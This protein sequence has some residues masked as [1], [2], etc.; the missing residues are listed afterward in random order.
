MCKRRSDVA[1]KPRSGPSAQSAK[2]ADSLRT[3][4]SVFDVESLRPLQQEAIDADMQQRDSLCVLPTGHGKSL[5]YQGPAIFGSGVTVV[6]S[7]LIAL[8]DDQVASISSGRPNRPGWAAALHSGI[9]PAAQAKIEQAVT[10]G[11]T[12]LLYCSPERALTPS[13]ITLLK[14]AGLRSIVID[15]AHCISQWGH[16]FRPDYAQ[17]GTLRTVFADV[18]MHAFTATA[19]P[20]V[21]ADIIDSLQLR[22]PL[23]LIG[24]IDR[25]NLHLIIHSPPYQ[26]GAGGVD[27]RT[28]DVVEFVRERADV[29]GIVYCITR[30]ETEQL[31]DRLCDAGLPA[32]HYHAGMAPDDRRQV[33]QAFMGGDATVVVATIAFGMGI[34]KPDIRYVL[35]A[36]MPSSI[37][38]YHQ[39]IGRA[40]RDGAPADCV[41]FYDSGDITRWC[42]IFSN[43]SSLDDDACPLGH[44]RDDYYAAFDHDGVTDV[45]LEDIDRRLVHL[46]AMAQFCQSSTCRHSY[47]VCYLS[48]H[49]EISRF[50][51][52]N[53]HA[54]DI[55]GIER[56]SDA[57]PAES[58]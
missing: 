54:C 3:I 58:S 33:H 38:V 53:C 29:S 49:E 44:M 10:S 52:H 35:H 15:E 56:R 7:P 30:K 25:P 12:K 36:A 16:D 31:A 8:M 1:T 11:F 19:K 4:L 14:R 34:D 6:V 57:E 26:G 46:R 21:Q 27:A 18:A 39:E 41:L 20:H 42:D 37:E 47:L 17:L 45:D 51:E 50:F 24:D 5:C 43:F 22:D 9:H 2:S 23:T 48:E 40:G 55:C 32:L 28:T 13:T